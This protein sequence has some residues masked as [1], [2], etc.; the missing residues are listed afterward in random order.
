MKKG[1]FLSIAAATALFVSSLG[2]NSA[3]ASQ[4]QVKTYKVS[5]QFNQE[6]INKMVESLL[7]QVGSQYQIDINKLLEQ[8]D[9]GK[10]TKVVKKPQVVSKPNNPTPAQPAKPTPPPSNNESTTEKEP[11]K[12]ESS[13]LSAYEQEVVDLTNAER[14]KEGLPALKV[15]EKLSEVARIK[16]ADMQSNRYFD[17]N[18]PTYG[19]PFDMMKSFGVSYRS[20]GENIAYGQK[21][22]QEVVT[23][24]MNS[25]GHRDNIMNSSYTHIGVGYV[26]QGNYWTQMFIGK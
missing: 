3:D 20:A 9:L 5:Y 22:P 26:E 6:D 15:D 16:S 24:W 13:K 2:I 10:N 11:T 8:I 23:A 7:A 12:E 14:A 25:K 4:V 1:M 21:T 19:S 17:H 18:S